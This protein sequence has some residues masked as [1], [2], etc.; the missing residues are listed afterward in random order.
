MRPGG[1]CMG[2]K[3]TASAA[4]LLVGTTALADDLWSLYEPAC[5]SNG[6][7]AGPCRCIFEV[8]VKRHGED[9]ARYIALDM[10]L[11]YDEAAALLTSVGEDAAFAAS[12]TFDVARNKDC[13]AARL[14]RRAGTRTQDAAS[15]T[16]ATMAAESAQQIDAARPDAPAREGRL[17]L[18]D[19]AA[20]VI[21]LRRDARDVVIEVDAIFADS[22]LAK[23]RA[24]NM[25][26]FVGFFVVADPSG[27]IDTNGDGTADVAP[28][29]D[30]YA[31]AA[32]ARTLRPKL[33]IDQTAGSEQYLGEI[34]LEPGKLYAPIVR[35]QRRQPTNRVLDSNTPDAEAMQTAVLRGLTTN[36]NLLFGVALDAAPAGLRAI[37]GDAFSAV[38]DTSDSHGNVVFKMRAVDYAD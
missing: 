20:P 25:R 38:L 26:N 1:D 24:T 18:A 30:G 3:L 15:G 34:R 17:L 37:E 28:Q 23:T 4:L 35:L 2:T 32:Q 29:D 14:A 27:G 12:D 8:V 5:A 31:T 13:T 11:R 21:D 19:S 9:A 36:A 16:V 7:D 6:I 22:A 10:V 33:Y